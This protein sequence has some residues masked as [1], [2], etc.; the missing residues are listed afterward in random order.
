MKK[1]FILVLI[2][3][4][5]VGKYSAA[6]FIWTGATN[7]N[8]N[9]AANWNPSTSIPSTGDNVQFDGSSVVNCT[10]NIN[11]INSF[12][13][14]SGYTGIITMASGTRTIKQNFVINAGTVISTSGSL[15][16]A[17]NGLA[18]VFSVGSGGTFTHNSGTFILNVDG[19]DTYTF[20][21]AITL[22]NFVLGTVNN[23]GERI[24]NF[25][26]NL[27][28]NVFSLG[29][30]SDAI[31]FQGTIHI[32]STLNLA[33]ATYTDVLTGPNN[34]NFIFDG[35]SATIVGAG[36]AGEVWL[37]NIQLNTAGA[38]NLSGNLNVQ[39]DWTATQ[40]GVTNGT[41]V[42]N[43]YGTSKSITGVPSFNNL[44]L[45]TGS[46]I[47]F[48]T[49]TEV[50]ITKDFTNNTTLTLPTTCTLS[51]NGNGTQAIAGTGFTAGSLRQY[52]GTVNLNVAVNLIDALIVDGGTFVTGNNLTLKSN[53]SGTAR[54]GPSAGTISGNV[55]V[56]TFIPGGF[57]GWTNMSSHGVQGQ[58]VSTW[59]KFASSGGTNGIPMTCVGCTYDPSTLNGFT[60]ISNYIEST[61]TYVDMVSSD[62]L[63]P[64]VGYWVY[65][66][67]GQTNT[68]AL[69]LINTGSIVQGATTTPVSNGAGGGFNL[70]A[71]PYPSPISW[72]NLY[73]LVAGNFGSISDGIQIWNPD[74][75][76]GT[77]GF[78]TFSTLSGGTNGGSDVIAGG[79]GF[80]VDNSNGSATTLNFDE[81]AKTDVAGTL[82]RP[83]AT[84][85]IQSV[86][87]KISGDNNSSDET[88][89]ASNANAT[90][91]F[92]RK[93]DMR[94][95]FQS[96]GYQGYPGP[97]TKYTTISTKDASNQDYVVNALPPLTQ[98]VSIPLL[99]KVSASG[100]FTIS[101]IEFK[102]FDMCVG[103]YDKAANIYHDLRQSPYV[104]MINDTTSAPRFE[105]IICED[106]NQ[107]TV[108]VSK[109]TAPS[110]ILI[111]QDAEGAFVKTQFSQTTKA[112]ISVYN[113]MGQQ[114]MNDAVVDG[115]E[116]MTHLNLNMHNQV[117]LIK[118]TTDKETT[119]KKLVVQ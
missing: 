21:G 36:A 73:Q 54:V 105:V 34:G 19:G 15:I 60:S 85:T 108:G 33:A 6:D 8:A 119:V 44:T 13:V 53:G 25:G 113:I 48:P 47:N 69:N 61:D 96:P 79:Q 99:A 17:N 57:T 101:A 51:F 74:L 26:S 117:V 63:S 56:E 92:D 41:S 98:S 1:I 81:V 102:N 18:S 32:G 11:T 80:Y 24:I 50:F 22:N 52:N 45:Q 110:S 42:V 66:G 3:T 84:S 28:A 65:V 83:A 72:F 88:I 12:S 58:D 100:N 31:S 20:S 62:P 76:G 64:C 89:I 104:F 5:F 4:C 10:W 103:L 82:L 111:N 87:L 71:N 27:S 38:V 77:G 116:T 30:T 14:L 16:K 70:V 23:G 97:Y 29:V 39:G 112:T 106:K 67:D 86:K 118:V 55:T 68:N 115:K 59:D 49:G 93:Y 75:S 109:F 9:V 78:A 91:S 114:L 95:M 107:N 37:P 40:G 35:S 2:I 94:K 90:T 46:S 7:S 43:L